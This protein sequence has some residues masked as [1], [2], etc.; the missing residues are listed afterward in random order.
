MKKWEILNQSKIKDKGLMIK[1][2]IKILLENRRV[3]TK[4]EIEEFLN[5]KLETVTTA[6]VGI[7]KKQLK[8]AI[9]RI[10]LAI[11]NKEQVV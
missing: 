1:D 7:D 3:K 6:D 4:K 5:P 9:A 8:K 2:L 11:K 10:K